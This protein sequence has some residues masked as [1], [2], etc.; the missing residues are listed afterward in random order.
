MIREKLHYKSQM[1]EMFS[2]CFTVDEDIIKKYQNEFPQI[3][4]DVGRNATR[5]ELNTMVLWS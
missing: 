3:G 5:E 2:P 4:P 1:L